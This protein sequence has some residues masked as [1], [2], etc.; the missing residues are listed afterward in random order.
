MV[1][2]ARVMGY[3]SMVAINKNESWCL[4]FWKEGKGDRQKKIKMSGYRSEG[5]NISKA[6]LQNA[7]TR[8]A[9]SN[10]GS[11]R[12]VGKMGTYEDGHGVRE[13]SSS[14]ANGTLIYR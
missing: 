8:P 10:A 13:V 2:L 6:A 12:R 5:R 4:H 1:V 9:V 7:L 14:R 11:R 3:Q